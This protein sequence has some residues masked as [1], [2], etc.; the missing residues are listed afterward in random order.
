MCLSKAYVYRGEGKEL[1]ME[2]VASLDIEDGKLRLKNLFGKE[3]EI[4]ASIRQINFVT[5]SIF[6]EDLKHG[7]TG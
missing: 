6:L 1:L 4:D 2:E 7:D 3:R 5:H